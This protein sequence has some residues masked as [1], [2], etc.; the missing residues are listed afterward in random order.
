VLSLAP[1]DAEWKELD[2]CH[3]TAVMGCADLLESIICLAPL[4]F[5][6]AQTALARRRAL[7]SNI[8]SI[9]RYAGLP[10]RKLVAYAVTIAFA[11]R[12]MTFTP[13]ESDI[14]RLRRRREMSHIDL[15][16][17]RMEETFPDLPSLLRD[18]S[19]SEWMARAES[20]AKSNG[21]RATFIQV[22]ANDGVTNDP[23]FA[24]LKENR[25]SWLGVQVEPAS[26]NFAKLTALHA[27]QSP[28]WIF[29]KSVVTDACD[30]VKGMVDFYAFDAVKAAAYEKRCRSKEPEMVQLLNCPTPKTWTEGGGIPENLR[31]GQMNS[32]VARTGELRANIG[33]ANWYLDMLEYTRSAIPLP[34][35]DSIRA[36]R[37]SSPAMVRE[38]TSEGSADAYGC[39]GC[40]IDLLQIDVEGE[41]W[42][43]LKTLGSFREIRPLL[44]NYEHNV[45]EKA[46]Y[47]EART[48][49]EKEGYLLRELYGDTLAVDGREHDRTLQQLHRRRS[50]M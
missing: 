34:C 43:V 15:F 12:V 7:A 17:P 42:N 22:G 35:F 47:L 31:E 36:L 19:L 29:H 10:V 40:R 4:L 21:R 41:D 6:F 3:A 45:L 46:D 24:Y 48:Y 2:E 23:L 33:K 39:S 38:A 25:D 18:L 9:A 28:E 16:M 44:I 13:R 11:Y 27:A 26:H 20:A 37:D 8:R 5:I 1:L 30:P 14:A 49:L 50:G 32:L